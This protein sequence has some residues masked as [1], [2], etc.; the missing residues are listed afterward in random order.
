VCHKQ[1]WTAEGREE[2]REEGRGVG[3]LTYSALVALATLLAIGVAELE[4]RCRAV[5]NRGLY[6]D[7]RLRVMFL[8]P[9]VGGSLKKIRPKRNHVVAAVA[10]KQRSSLT[11]GLVGSLVSV[12]GLEEAETRLEVD[13]YVL[14]VGGV[15]ADH[16]LAF[17]AFKHARLL[18]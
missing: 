6:T 7:G 16:V 2:G 12:A 13:A 3:R 1:E 10:N 14:S 11:E 5:R 4:I 15:L 18:R 17:V 8:L 9:L